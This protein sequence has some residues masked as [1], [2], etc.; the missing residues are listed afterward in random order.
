MTRTRVANLAFQIVQAP[1]NGLSFAVAAA[2]SGLLNGSRHI[3]AR[4]LGNGL[5]GRPAQASVAPY[6]LAFGAVKDG[7][8]SRKAHFARLESGPFLVRP[9]TFVMP[10]KAGIQ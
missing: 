3:A 6:S 2:A 1:L 7:K 5:K 4:S 10:A 8:T 9:S